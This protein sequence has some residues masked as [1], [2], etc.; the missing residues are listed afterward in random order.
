MFKT[1]L[2]KIVMPFL[3]VCMILS[4][5]LLPQ[6]PVFAEAQKGSITVN[7]STN[8]HTVPVSG[9]GFSLVKIFDYDSTYG[10]YTLRPNAEGYGI[11]IEDVQ[12]DPE[13]AA[14]DLAGKVKDFDLR[15]TTN[16]QGIAVFRELPEGVYLMVETERSGDAANYEFSTP[17][18][19]QVP[20]FTGEGANYDITAYPKTSK[21]VKPTTPNTPKT[22]TTVKTG[23]ANNLYAWI[24]ATA[25][26]ILAAAAMIIHGVKGIR[27]NRSVQ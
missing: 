5:M 16:G 6:T 24:A 8:N 27:K 22:P 12:A 26:V 14:K 25:A 19:I 18:I 23:D 9:G 2:K 20:E 11:K 4:T 15:A 3:A 1:F 21:P 13:A 7:F 10:K 17:A